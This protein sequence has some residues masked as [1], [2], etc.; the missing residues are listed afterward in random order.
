V[1]LLPLELNDLRTVKKFASQTLEKL[2]SDKLDILF[3]N[4]ALVK[5]ADEPGINGS[6]WSEQYV[7]NHLCQ[8]T[9]L[10][11]VYRLIADRIHFSSTLSPPSLP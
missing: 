7:V 10:F 8:Q 1:T 4:A 5:S 2:G 11:V 6:K 9:A 3:L